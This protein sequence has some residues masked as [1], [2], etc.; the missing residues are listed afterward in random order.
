MKLIK[1]GLHNKSGI[2]LMST[3]WFKWTLLETK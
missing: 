2:G 3:I 1:V